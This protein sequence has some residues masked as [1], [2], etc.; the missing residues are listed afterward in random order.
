[1]NLIINLAVYPTW[2]KCQMYIFF[3]LIIRMYSCT[4]KIENT[5]LHMVLVVKN[6]PANAGD[7]RDM[8]LI[9]GLGRSPGDQPTPVFRP[10][11]P[12]GESSLVGY[13]PWGSQ[14]AGH[15][16]WLTL[17]YVLSCKL[18]PIYNHEGPEVSKV[19]SDHYNS[20]FILSPAEITD[21]KYMY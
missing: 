20:P 2:T 12:H 10:G 8:G 21:Q 3:C 4:L 14:R 18:K 19:F 11:K 7:I 6:L 16:V 15:T 17:Y 9:P 13:S 5:I 1:M